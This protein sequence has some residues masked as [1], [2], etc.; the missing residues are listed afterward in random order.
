MEQ[1]NQPTK[2][3]AIRL[4]IFLLFA[5]VAPIAYLII[6]YG[7]F[8]STSGLGVNLAGL[9][10]AGIML[11]VGAVL[12]KYYIESMKTKF[13]YAKQILMGVLKLI[14]PLFVFLLVLIWLGDNLYILKESLIVIIP[15]ELVAVIVNPFPKWCFENNIDG[16]GMIYEKIVSKRKED[17][18]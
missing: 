7:L 4:V 14:L 9:I 13:S 1:E 5:V 3:N 6:R 18:K 11:G 15:C 8:K 16:L 10:S 12:I 2:L 17:N